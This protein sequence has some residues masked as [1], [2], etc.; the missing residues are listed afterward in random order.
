[1]T[2][3]LKIS[4]IVVEEN[5]RKNFSFVEEI[6]DSIKQIGLLQPIVVRM[7]ESKYVLVDGEQRLRALKQLKREEVPVHV[8][9]FDSEQTVKESR[10]MA[11][12]MR[13][14]LSYIE[15]LR[16]FEGLMKTAPA[17]YNERV[18][19]NKF[20]LK[21]KDVKQAIAL[22]GKIDPACDD[23]LASG[24][25]ESNDFETISR[26][27]KDFQKQLVEHA[28]KK[29]NVS[30]NS[31][32]YEM[33]E[34]LYFDDVFG[35]AQA[36][37]AGKVHYKAQYGRPRTFDKAYGKKVRE[38]F[39][40][41]TKKNYDA[42]R[43]QAREKDSKQKEMTVEQV[44]KAREKK[45]KDAAESLDRLQSVIKSFLAK[46][47]NASDIGEIIADKMNALWGGDLKTILRAFGV[48]YKSDAGTDELR[49]LAHKHVF[50]PLVQKDY[51]VVN[52]IQLLAL[53]RSQ[54]AKEWAKVIEKA[55]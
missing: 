55:K 44:K 19:A 36:K 35:E 50:G 11:N 51:Q 10:L 26:V 37:A 2:Q 27:S 13:S 52:L 29:S 6:A 31:S 30:I 4:E 12:L 3:T 7:K 43:K 39:E 48:E 17:K 5:P 32:I 9:T 33:T 21:E 47:P 54:D 34:E 1:M 18:I 45:K 46:K 42:E 41:R 22:A 24:R 8:V 49:K 15:R 14:N 25:I 16:G 20:G 23:V 40:A 53:N 38:E 28:A